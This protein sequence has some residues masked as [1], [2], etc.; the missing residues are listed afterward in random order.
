MSSPQ[1]DHTPA[2]RTGDRG[3]GPPIDRVVF[4]TAAAAIAAFVLWGVL[5]SENMAS[6]V[7][8]AF[9]QV[10]ES[11]GW[12]FVLASTGFVVLALILAL[13]RY[14]SIRLGKDDD[15]PEFSTGSWIAML[16]A[17]GMGI[18][19]VFWGVAEPLYHL[20]GPPLDQA[21]PNSVE[22]G[23]LALQ[24]AVFHWG[25]HP[26]AMYAVIALAMAYAVFRKG[27][28]N[29]VSSAVVPLIGEH[30]TGVRRAVDILAI[31]AT[32]FGAAT[33]LGLGA[34]Q[35]NSGLASAY[36]VP[37]STTVALVVVAALVVLYVLSAASGVHKGIK[38]VSNA[39]VILA[40]VVAAFL[41]VFGPTIYILNTISEVGGN[42]LSQLLSMSFTTG[43]SGGQE[44]MAGW[45][46][47]YWAWWVS[48]TPFVGT[49]IARISRGRTIREFVAC[50]MIV[51]TIVSVVWFSILGGTAINL[52]L[53]GGAALGQALTDTGAEGALFSLLGEFPLAALTATLVVVL[54]TLFFVSSA[55][56]ASLVLGMLSQ[57]GTV[58]PRRALVIG[59]GCAI[60]GVA[61]AL[62]MAGGLAAMQ[63]AT[64]LVSTPF[65]VV[66]IAICVNLVRELRQEPRTP[67][68]PAAVGHSRASN[69][70]VPASNGVPAQVDSTTAERHPVK[71]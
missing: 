10:I 69:G 11:T 30:R 26:W 70:A 19:L 54:I 57:Q 53:G 46:L 25:L 28:P 51:P 48:W 43:A 3:S 1:L 6:V 62:L 56:S 36:G 24:Y 44:W 41:F 45:T 27:R 63:S 21:E 14:G 60:G 58:T 55:D 31:F 65:L 9:A 61:M 66:L 59:W 13:S 8:T 22:S 37:Q 64:I 5:A 49:F 4:G 16:F 42:Y 50:V 68:P 18:G 23:Q 34:L 7:S 39:N 20:A 12:V 67:V 52:E 38:L 40:G 2:D 47:F 71:P 35:I 29:L 33:S 17:A 15:R 32:V